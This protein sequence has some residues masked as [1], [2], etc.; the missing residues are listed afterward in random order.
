M[1]HS[2]GVRDL[3]FSSL[4]DSFLS[5]SFDKTIKEWD[6]ETGTSN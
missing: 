3:D 4:G 6:T 5:C 2:K 1:G